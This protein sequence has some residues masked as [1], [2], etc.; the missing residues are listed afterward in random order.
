MS[1]GGSAEDAAAA[2]SVEDS[3]AI[4]AE[5]S[6]AAVQRILG[7]KSKAEILLLPEQRKPLDKV[8]KK[9]RRSKLVRIH[10]AREGGAVDGC[11]EEV[12]A[13]LRTM[14]GIPRDV[15]HP[16]NSSDATTAFHDKHPMLLSDIHRIENKYLDDECK[17]F[18]KRHGLGNVY[19][20]VYH[21]TKYPAVDLIAEQGFAFGQRQVWGL[22]LYTAPEIWDAFFYSSPHDDGHQLAIVC[23]FFEGGSTVQAAQDKQSFGYDQYNQRVFTAQDPK[24]KMLIAAKA[25]QVR[26]FLCIFSDCARKWSLYTAC[27]VC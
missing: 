2:G 24:G 7:A 15:K 19:R 4:A 5:Q 10:D 8:P 21:G 18:R 20:I 25:E 16:R 13:L 22:G 9:E 6:A 3:A 12:H 14:L 11:E 27:G 23:E 26:N 1:C 17:E